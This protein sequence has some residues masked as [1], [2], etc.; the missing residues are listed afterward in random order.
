MSSEIF[1]CCEK[2]RECREA[3][4]CV[5]PPIVGTNPRSGEPMTI[6]D[7]AQCYRKRLLDAGEDPWRPA[8]PVIHESNPTE[9]A[10]I[11]QPTFKPYSYSLFD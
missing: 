6:F 10:R 7:P 11:E 3:G 8:W 4:S 9:E 1:G 5:A 2:W